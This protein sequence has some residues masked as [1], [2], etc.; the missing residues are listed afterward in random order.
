MERGGRYESVDIGDSFCNIDR[1]YG[2]SLVRSTDEKG[3]R[4]FSYGL[5]DQ[6]T[7]S[8]NILRSDEASEERS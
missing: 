1:R 8:H 6:P 4:G 7:R 3:V 2:V 5:D